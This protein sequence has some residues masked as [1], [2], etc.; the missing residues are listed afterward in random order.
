[1]GK[2]I[3][4]TGATGFAGGHATTELLKRGHRLVALVRDPARARLPGEV[5]VVKGDLEKAAAGDRED[6]A[7]VAEL[8]RGADAIVHLAGAIAA[9]RPRNFFSANAFATRA[10]AQAA[11]DAGVRRFVHVSSLAAREQ[12]LS[13]YAVSKLLAEEVLK[14]FGG[15]LDSVALRAPVI[16]GPGDRGTLPLMRELTHGIAMIP[17]R[18]NARFSLIHAEDFARII[19]DAVTGGQ[20][21]IREV[22]DG[23]VGG[24]GWDDLLAVAGVAEGRTIRPVFLPKLIV[25]GAAVVAGGLSRMTGKASMV[26]RGKVNELYH[27]DWVSRGEDWPIADPITFKTGFPSTVAW[28]RREGWLPPGRGTDRRRSNHIE[29]TKA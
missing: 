9:V 6:A 11:A 12:E 17:G 4:I 2:T 5:R 1:M 14:T 10:L 24:Y 26:S 28:Y 8:V 27:P 21:G 7:A 20:T 16:Y 23:T 29:K 19:A 15:V 13:I 25:A 22:S 3:A 18:R